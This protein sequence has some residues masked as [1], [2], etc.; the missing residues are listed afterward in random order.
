MKKTITSLLMVTRLLGVVQ[1]VVGLAIWFSLRNGPA[2]V[3]SGPVAFHSAVGS[4]FVLVMGIISVICLFVLPR[5][6]VALFALFWSGVVLWLGMAQ[7][8]LAVGSAHWTVRVAH[9]V[10]G[11]AALGLIEALG[12]ATKRHWAAL[13]SG[14]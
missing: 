8:S 11:L 13:H 4:L 6:A 1:I 9:L 14:A 12:G 5:R 10:V 3:H 7:T 2:A